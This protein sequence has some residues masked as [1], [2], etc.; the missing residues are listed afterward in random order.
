MDESRGATEDLA[1]RHGV[2]VFAHG[3][4]GRTERVGQPWPGVD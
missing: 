4:A 1:P 2:G 3:S